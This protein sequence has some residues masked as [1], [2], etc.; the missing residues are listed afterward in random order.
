[1]KIWPWDN[2]YETFKNYY[3]S[4]DLIRNL[5]SNLKKKIIFRFKYKN[6]KLN[7][8]KKFIDNISEY[9]LDQNTI[10]KNSLFNSSKLIIFTY[11]STALYEALSL[12]IP[13][14]CLISKPI[15]FYTKKT[16]KIFQEMIKANIFF[17]NPNLMARHV[18][19][20]ENDIDHWWKSKKVLKA[21]NVF[22]YNLSSPV[23]DDPYTKLS[24]LLLKLST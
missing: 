10:Q 21:K 15:Y 19:K 11:E 3:L 24:N 2:Y 16:Q 22:K 17:T 4:G 9:K 23:G 20:N 14:V 7:F 5:N 8:L 6:N 18:N 13:C 1:M 12:D